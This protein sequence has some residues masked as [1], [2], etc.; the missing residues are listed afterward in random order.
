VFCRLKKSCLVRTPCCTFCNMSAY[1]SSTYR[2]TA[3][4][5]LT[6]VD[7]IHN[8][9]YTDHFDMGIDIYICTLRTF[10][11][12]SHHRRDSAQPTQPYIDPRSKIY[13]HH[14]KKSLKPIKR[15][16]AISQGTRKEGYMLLRRQ[17]ARD[18]KGMD[19]RTP[20]LVV[21]LRSEPNAICCCFCCS[22][23]CCEDESVASVGSVN[24]RGPSKGGSR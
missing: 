16:Y 17:S 2:H 3:C 15:G 20:D 12:T 18:Y 22:N 10:P 11:C 23:V 6:S 24:R 5:R 1:L 21:R 9:E 8:Q 19:T 14:T 4:R 13:E 7:S